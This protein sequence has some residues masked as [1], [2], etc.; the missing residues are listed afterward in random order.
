MLFPHS[1]QFALILGGSSGIGLATARKLAA[2]GLHLCLVHRDRR[3][4]LPAVEAS[5]AE[6]RATGRTV[7]TFN[8]NA[9]QAEKQSEVIEALGQAMGGPGRLRVLIH[10]LSRGNLKRLSPTRPSLVNPQAWQAAGIDP[11]SEMGQALHTLMQPADEPGDALSMGDL[12]LTIEAM[13][14]SLWS[15]TQQ[16]LAAGAF[17]SDARIIG[18]TS[19][20]NQRAWPHY[21]AVSAAKATLE[22][23]IRAMARE[24]APHGIRSNVVQAGITDTPS[25]RMIPGSEQLKASALLRNPFGRLTTP[26]D[27]ANVIALLS[28]EEAAWIN[29]ALIP[30]DGGERLG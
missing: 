26:T 5:F 12:A 4:Q 7:L 22:S 10:A 15:W 13:A 11:G 9:L 2:E 28:S 1:D 3:S 17:A 8:L 19:E 20:G 16:L 23:L 6:L 21:A 14:S 18:L 24:L 30:V 29:G 27:V 25:L